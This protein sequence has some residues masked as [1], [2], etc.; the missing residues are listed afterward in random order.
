MSQPAGTNRKTKQV[1]VEIQDFATDEFAR[2]VR[3]IP[4]VEVRV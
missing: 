4:L 1:E 2:I 3:K